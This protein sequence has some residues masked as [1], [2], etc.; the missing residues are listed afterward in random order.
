M[1]IHLRANSPAEGIRLSHLS[2]DTMII[3]ESMIGLI[4]FIEP[5]SL[6]SP[7]NLL[8][9]RTAFRNVE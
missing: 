8:S 9:L 3:L 2:P 4:S 1:D 5:R 6:V 7:I